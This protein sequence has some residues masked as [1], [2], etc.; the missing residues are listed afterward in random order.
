MEIPDNLSD[1]ESNAATLHI[2]A[3]DLAQMHRSLAGAGLE[4]RLVRTRSA[5]EIGSIL[6]ALG[7]G[8]GIAA[9]LGS[10]GSA[11]KDYF[12]AHGEHPGQHKDTLKLKY[13]DLELECMAENVDA[14][15]D[16]VLRLMAKAK[17]I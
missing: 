8:T 6:L 3:D 11:L 4:E 5:A 10:V 13:G 14:V 9:I 12:Q 17:T 2:L 7:G 15:V 1:P 16:T